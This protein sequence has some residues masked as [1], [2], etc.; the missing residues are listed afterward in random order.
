[1]FQLEDSEFATAAAVKSRVGVELELQETQHQL[2]DMIRS[3]HEAEER[4]IQLSR[5]KNDLTGHLEDNEEEFAELL[6]KYKA[7]VAQVKIMWCGL[8]NKCCF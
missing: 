3:K 1:M 4:L 8:E 5:E 7:A 2:E 6:K